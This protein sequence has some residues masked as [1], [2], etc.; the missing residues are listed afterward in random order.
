MI[1]E[2]SL[3]NFKSFK[4]LSNLKLKPLTI[5]AGKNSCGKSSIIQSI[6]LL[7]QTIDSSTKSSLCLDGKYLKNS[8]LSEITHGLP[9][10]D[11]ARIDY[12]LSIK[13]EGFDNSVK[14][15]FYTKRGETGVF[16]NL[17]INKKTTV[18]DEKD[19][20]YKVKN[21][22]EITE[23]T[24]QKTGFLKH[25]WKE[26]KISSFEILKDKFI[27]NR[28]K[29]NIGND[30]GISLPIQPFIAES[31]QRTIELLASDL[32]GVR[33]LSPIRAM[34]QRHQ[35]YYSDDVG[36]L[37]NDGSNSPHVFWAK[38]SE[39]VKFDGVETSLSESVNKCLSLLGLKQKVNPSKEGK[40][41]YN[42]TIEEPVSN[43][44]VSLAD[45][46]FGYSQVVPVILLGL[47]NRHK[48]ILVEQPEIH[49]HPSAAANLADL[50]I[51][52]SREN[53]FL[54]ETHSQ[55]FINRLRLRVIENPS[56]AED[57][58]IV[59]VN[60]TE[61]EGAHIKQFT[62]DPNGNFPEWPEGFIDESE[63][64]ARAIIKARLNAKK[65]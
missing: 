42:I 14:I 9:R 2:L 32:R 34:P 23:A 49:L 28:I 57:I 17:T 51:K 12:E 24:I 29:I 4:D 30:R 41:L 13:D 40:V 6:L 58:N 26:E 54:I 61:G 39:I 20:I 19:P 10:K 37:S 22:S 62:I 56:I 52:F 3:K 21:T 53:R 8:E 33:Y 47:L 36:E 1:T 46:G 7:K 44:K 25:F 11:R 38:R 60:S 63:K 27:P 35:I 31:S 43:K 64:I 59:F 50:F 16:S 45:V 65:E 18:E 55:E 5:I 48:L 15:S